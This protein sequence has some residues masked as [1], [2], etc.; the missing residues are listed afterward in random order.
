ML[1]LERSDRMS[2]SGHTE[3][4]IVWQARVVGD[5]TKLSWEENVFEWLAT[6]SSAVGRLELMVLILYVGLSGQSFYRG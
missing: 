2:A 3:G 6:L 1:H 5:V 4:A